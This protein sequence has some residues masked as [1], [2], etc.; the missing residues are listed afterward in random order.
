MKAHSRLLG[1]E[2]FARTSD[3]DELYLVASSDPAEVGRVAGEVTKNYW[4]DAQRYT[5]LREISNPAAIV[6]PPTAGPV[7]LTRTITFEKMDLNA[8]VDPSLFTLPPDEPQP[9]GP[10]PF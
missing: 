6:E 4:I 1:L 2:I 5:V 10:A 8:P 9:T 7:K 3:R